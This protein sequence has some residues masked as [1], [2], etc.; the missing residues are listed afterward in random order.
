M[1]SSGSDLGETPPEE[2][3]LARVSVETLATLAAS[4]SLTARRGLRCRSGLDLGRSF[5][6]PCAVLTLPCLG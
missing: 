6:P 2:R 5:R 1:G 3:P 4:T